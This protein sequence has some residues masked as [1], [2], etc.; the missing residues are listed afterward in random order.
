MNLYPNPVLNT[1]EIEVSEI[2]L[3]RTTIRIHNS[4]GL[5]HEVILNNR[6]ETSC[7]LSTV[8]LPNGIYYLIVEV[9]STFL[10]R[11][12]VVHK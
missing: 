3:A 7:Q 8:H 11:R 12:F 10:T 5:V 1:L 2:D 4:V 9:G 6:T